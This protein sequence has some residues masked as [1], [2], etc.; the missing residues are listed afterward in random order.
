MYNSHIYFNKYIKKLTK[1][2]VIK[3]FQILHI[4]SSIYLGLVYRYFST[5]HFPTLEELEVYIETYK[6]D[7]SGKEIELSRDLHS[8]IVVDRGIAY[9]INKDK[10]KI[11]NTSNVSL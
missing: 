5:R 6:D 2:L 8:L 3:K 7:L 1:T 11:I 4:C 9:K 10:F